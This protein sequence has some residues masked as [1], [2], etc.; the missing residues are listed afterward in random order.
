MRGVLYSEWLRKTGPDLRLI[1]MEYG[2]QDP[3][4]L[5]PDESERQKFIAAIE[6]LPVALKNEPLINTIFERS[7]T[8]VTIIDVL[9]VIC[10]HPDH[11]VYRELARMGLDMKRLLSAHTG[12]NRRSDKIPVYS[13]SRKDTPGYE[14]LDRICENLTRQAMQGNFSHLV[15]RPGAFNSI[16]FC[17]S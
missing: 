6:T 13:L 14:V 3:D 4:G 7:K 5:F 12:R 16:C 8:A 1:L 11:P 2:K 9:S 17:A 10:N 15:S